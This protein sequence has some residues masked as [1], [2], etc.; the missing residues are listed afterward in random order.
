MYGSELHRKLNRSGREFVGDWPGSSRDHTKNI[1][2]EAPIV[3]QLG[4]LIIYSRGGT[5]AT[6]SSG[7]VLGPRVGTIKVADESR[8]EV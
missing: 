8:F 5:R 4:A 7:V 2:V 6:C 3:F 1:T